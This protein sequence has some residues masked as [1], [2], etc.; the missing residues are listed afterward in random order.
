MAKTI[1]V[2]DEEAQ[3]LTDLLD[4]WREGYKDA[5]E[6]TT[7]DRS[8]DMD[9]VLSLM[10]NYSH[11]VGMCDSLTDKLSREESAANG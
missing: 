5:Q 3:F 7:Q 11:Q 10:G 4:W 6:M 8:L 1:D 9:Q 2:T